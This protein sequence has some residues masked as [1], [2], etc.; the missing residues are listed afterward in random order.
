MTVSDLIQKAISLLGSEA[1]LAAAC[2]VSQ[3]A[4]NSAKQ[5]G[6]VSAKLAKKIES[7]TGGAVQ[8]HELCPDVFDPPPYGGPLGPRADL[9]MSSSSSSL[10][11]EEGPKNGVSEIANV[12][13]ENANAHR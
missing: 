8:K 6:S 2:G 1:K 11:G 4:I 3:P 5:A 12:G 10:A 9:C 13:A 7:A